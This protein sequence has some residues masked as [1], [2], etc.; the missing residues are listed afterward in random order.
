MADTGCQS[1]L[2][3]S[4]LLAKLHL[5]EAD[6]IPVNLT[7]HSASGNNL[8]ILGAAILRLIASL[9]GRETRQMVYFSNIASKLY[10]S[11]ATCID[12]RLLPDDFPHGTATP[13]PIT[14]RERTPEADAEPDPT[15]RPDL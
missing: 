13:Q 8:P 1:C 15:C 10:P 14:A 5:T 4:Q 6:L 3:A 11:L 7:M 12:L 9:N 2:A